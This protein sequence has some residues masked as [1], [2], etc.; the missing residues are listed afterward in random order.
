MTYIEIMGPYGSG[1]SA[2]HSKLITNKRL[3]GGRARESI[4]RIFLRE[5]GFDFSCIHHI[6]PSIFQ[7]LFYWKPYKYRFEDAAFTKFITDHPEFSNILS[8]VR[9]T[10]SEENELFTGLTFSNLKHTAIRYQLGIVA[11]NEYEHFI[12]DEGFCMRASSL[13][14]EKNISLKDYFQIIPIPNIVIHVDASSDLCMSRQKERGRVHISEREKMDEMR[15]RYFKIF[16]FLESHT[17]ASLI[18]VKNDE[19]ID[20]AVSKAEEELRK[21][22]DF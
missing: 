18:T 13:I 2:L 3:F 9:K 19:A 8:E 17:S 5:I 12:L 4:S 10:K 1:K 15:D 21:L 20:L 7:S 22:I 11:K 6:V 14:H 16:D